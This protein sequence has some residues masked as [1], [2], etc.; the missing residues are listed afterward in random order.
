MATEDT[1]KTAPLRFTA[2]ADKVL[3]LEKTILAMVTCSYLMLKCPVKTKILTMDYLHK[4]VDPIPITMV[5]RSGKHSLPA[6]IMDQ[7]MLKS[8]YS[9]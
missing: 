9:L 6:C 8:F 5:N 7:S 1:L 2:S 4:S 3:A